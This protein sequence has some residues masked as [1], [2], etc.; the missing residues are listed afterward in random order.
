[1]PLT[2]CPMS[3]YKLKV[4]NNPED[5]NIGE[6]L[7]LGI[8]VTINSDDPAYFGGYVSAN[9]EFLLKY[10]KPNRQIT[11]ADIKRLVENGFLASFLPF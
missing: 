10:S 4:Y 3:N 6:L 5:H 2:V 8:M 7:D 1:M 9:Y 11:L